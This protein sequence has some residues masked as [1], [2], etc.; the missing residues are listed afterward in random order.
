MDK[1]KIDLIDYL[2]SATL[3]DA[4]N[5]FHS[6]GRVRPL[7]GRNSVMLRTIGDNFNVDSYQRYYFDDF[8]RMKAMT[9]FAEFC[10][11][12]KRFDILDDRERLLEVILEAGDILFQSRVLDLR[13][14]ENDQYRD[15]RTKMNTAISYIRKELKKRGISMDTVVIISKIKYGIRSWRHLK[16]LAPKNKNLE[17]E[18]CLKRL[19]ELQRT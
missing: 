7:Y 8:R 18:F 15:A 6:S 4:V 5:I 10:D 16:G 19:S 3:E 11:A 12:L 14:K 17:K 9:E 13:H 2:K 1:E